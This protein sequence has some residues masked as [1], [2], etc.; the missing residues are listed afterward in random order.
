MAS[1]KTWDEFRVDLGQLHHVIGV[2]KSQH[3]LI[4]DALIRVSSEF[5]KC[6]DDWDT[7]SAVTFDNVKVW[8]TTA[9]TDLNAL[10][11]DMATRMQTAYNNYKHAEEVNVLNLKSDGRHSDSHGGGDGKHVEKMLLRVAAQPADGGD[12]QLGKLMLRSVMVRRSGDAGTEGALLALRR[13]PD[14]TD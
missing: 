13:L 5:D 9:S 12:G 3:D 10:L 7:P 1:P 8:L 14:A 4:S 11:S 6:R 2:V